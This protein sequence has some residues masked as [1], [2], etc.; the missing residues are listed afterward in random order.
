MFPR[1]LGFATALL[2]ISVLS[3]CAS[4]KRGPVALDNRPVRL[5]QVAL[6][7]EEERFALIETFSLA[8]PAEGTKLRIYRGDAVSAELRVTTV[9]RRPFLVADLVTGAPARGDLV[10]QA[11]SDNEFAPQAEPAAAPPAPAR[12]PL[13]RRWLA[14][15]GVRQ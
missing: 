6:V 14:P 3:G 5:G 15:F 7:N 4:R 12:P 13:W 11:R 10:F 2:V 1:R 8:T 9:R